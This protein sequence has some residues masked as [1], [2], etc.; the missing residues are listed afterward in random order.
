MDGQSATKNRKIAVS[1]RGLRPKNDGFRG[2][3]FLL[4]VISLHLTA[5]S[6]A[7]GLIAVGDGGIEL[8]DPD[9]RR[10]RRKGARQ[11]RPAARHGD[12][13]SK[14]CIIRPDSEEAAMVSERTAG[15]R[16]G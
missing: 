7:A 11:C 5:R 2:R 9:P 1:G 4:A 16:K 14:R 15:Y 8:F 3:L 6:A 12:V 13:A 10:R